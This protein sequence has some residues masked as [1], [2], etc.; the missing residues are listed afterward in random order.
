MVGAVRTSGINNGKS[1][2]RITAAELEATGSNLMNPI[3]R[4]FYYLLLVVH[5]MYGTYGIWHMAQ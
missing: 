5:N 2:L 1:S 3:R 4:L